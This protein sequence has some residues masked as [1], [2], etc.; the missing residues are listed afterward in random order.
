[1]F[2]LRAAV[3]VTVRQLEPE[4]L[5]GGKSLRLLSCRALWLLAYVGWLCWRTGGICPCALC[6]CR[7]NQNSCRFAGR[8]STVSV[9]YLSHRLHGGR[10]LPYPAGRY[11][12]GLGL[13]AS[14]SVCYSQ[15]L[16]A[17]C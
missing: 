5:D 8:A 3:V 17:R 6:R 4:C 15:C 11:R 12:G 1:M 16:H 2:L 7:P 14:R 10:K 9:R 13:R